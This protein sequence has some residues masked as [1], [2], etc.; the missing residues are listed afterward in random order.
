M[1]IPYSSLY[2]FVF[3]ECADPDLANDGFET[4]VYLNDVWRSND[5][6][7]SWSLVTSTAP[8]SGRYGHSSVALDSNTIVLMGGDA[9]TSKCTSSWK[10]VTE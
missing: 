4:Y 6:G 2:Y 3:H 9:A 10:T 7:T 5:K 8:W 1:S